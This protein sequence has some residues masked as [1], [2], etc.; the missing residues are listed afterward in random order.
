MRIAPEPNPEEVAALMAALAVV[1]KDRAEPEE[2]VAL[3]RSRWRQA[4]LLGHAPPR[5]MKLE[6]KLWAYLSWRA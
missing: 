4:G 2:N 1:W 3:K 6:G 5:E